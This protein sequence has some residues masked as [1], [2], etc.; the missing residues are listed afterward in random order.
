MNSLF[1]LEKIN[2]NDLYEK[3]IPKNSDVIAF[4][5]HTHKILS[6]HHISHTIIDDYVSKKD[7]EEFFRSASSFWNWYEKFHDKNFFFHDT[8]LLSIIDRNELHEFLMILIQKIK[9]IKHILEK[10]TYSKI[11]ASY[12]I[13]KLIKSVSS[14]E[15]II[16]EKN[17][18]DPSLTYDKITLSYGKIPSSIMPKIERKKF[19]KLKKIYENT[20]SLI[21]KLNQKLPDQ[22]KIILIEFNPEVYESLLYEM[23]RNN[24]QPVLLNFRRPATWSLNSI[25]ILR[26]TNSLVI[27]PK[28]VLESEKI[29]EI[30]NQTEI[31]FKKIKTSFEDNHNISSKLFVYE[32]IKFDHIMIELFLRILKERLEEYI[33]QILISEELNKMSNV[34]CGITL[35]LSGEMEKTFSQKIN[36]FPILLQQH[37]FSNYPEPITFFDILDD[38]KFYE[39]KIIAYGGIIQEYLF[40]THQIPKKNVL[41]CGSP[42]YDTF[43]PIIKK[44]E[45]VKTILI[46]LRPIIFHMEGLKI[47]LY[48]IYETAIVSIISACK[49]LSNVKLIFK[50]HPQQ[51]PNNDFLRNIIKKNYSDAKIIQFS[52]IRELFN[53]CDLHINIAPDNFD[54][55]SVVLE[56]MILKRPTLNIQLQ[57]NEIN[58]EVIQE[59]AIRSI[60]YDDEIRKEVNDLLYDEQKISHLLSNSQNYLKK[61]LFNH[62]TAAK[63]LINE[64]LKENSINR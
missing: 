18:S 15:T 60:M 10:N 26:K 54:I 63:T 47:D 50:L 64:I 34:L 45:N 30:K 23:F 62:G 57:S 27:S 51:N 53:D 5:H 29:S 19:V 37:A 58:F 9:I 22:K 61:Y 55:S 14:Y 16:F 44:S 24:I 48:N 12:E 20:V 11:Y 59:K 3:N 28:D 32:E 36:T 56:A 21:F 2:E 42:K 38:F 25:N 33:T 7:R 40:K 31:I 43:E 49:N 46:T 8:S 13:S 6:M 41:T 4:D 52:S 39:S 17:K 1:L 35:N